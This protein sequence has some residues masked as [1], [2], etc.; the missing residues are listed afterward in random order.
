MIIATKNADK[1]VLITKLTQLVFP[2]FWTQK[3]LELIYNIISKIQ[4]RVSCFSKSFFIKFTKHIFYRLNNNIFFIIF[5]YIK[6]PADIFS[7]ERKKSIA[8]SSQC[9]LMQYPNLYFFF[10]WW[11]DMQKEVNYLLMN[12]TA[13]PYTITS[14]APCITAEEA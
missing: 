7:G 13:V 14:A 2:N 1:T 5:Q 6:V 12:L 8:D 10:S 9:K 11:F 3:E 4:N